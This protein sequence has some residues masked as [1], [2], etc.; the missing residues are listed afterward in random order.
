[1]TTTT[2]IFGANIVETSK[3][4]FV[5]FLTDRKVGITVAVLETELTNLGVPFRKKDTKEAKAGLLFDALEEAGKSV[6]GESPV[7]ETKQEEEVAMTKEQLLE[8]KKAEI[9]AIREA[10]KMD[11]PNAAH[12][13]REM[14]FLKA[15]KGEESTESG[16]LKG[17]LDKVYTA[18]NTYIKN[19]GENAVVAVGMMLYETKK[20]LEKLRDSGS[21]EDKAYARAELRA[22]RYV[23]ANKYGTTFMG[24]I[25]F[26][27]PEDYMQVKIWNKKMKN[28]KT[29]RMGVAQWIPFNSS[30]EGAETYDMDVTESKKPRA[31]GSGL[32]TLPI[33]EGKDG[34]AFVGLPM[35]ADRKRAGVFYDLFRTSDNRFVKTKDAEYL[36]EVLYLGDNNRTFNAQATAFIRVFINQF[37]RENPANRHGFNESCDTCLNCSRLQSK[38]GLTDDITTESMKSRVLLESKDIMQ[39]AQVGPFEPSRICM[40]TG[41]IVDTDLTLT[42]NEATK[43][44]R[45]YFTDEDG[46]FRFQAPND[47][48]IA[49]KAYKVA[50]L[51]QKVLG[52]K[53]V[54]CEWY[55]GNAPKTEHQVGKEKASKRDALGL[56]GETDVFVNPFYRQT[57]RAGR[58]A[59]QTLVEVEGKNKWLTGLPGEVEGP[60]SFRVK[61]AGLTVY[62]SDEIM[63]YA[64]PEALP[65]L[66]AFDARHADVMSKINQIFYV[67]FNLGKVTPAQADAVFEMA[68]AP[69]A[70]MTEQEATKWTNAVYWL[71]QALGWAEEKEAAKHQPLFTQKFFSGIREGAIELHIEDVMGEKLSRKEASEFSTMTELASSNK[72]NR[73]DYIHSVYDDLNA[74]EFSRYLDDAA[75]DYVYTVIETGQD[76]CVVGGKASDTKLAIESLQ[77]MLQTELT[78]GFYSLAK[79]IN[80]DADPAA[81][82]EQLKACAE[83]KAYLKSI[84]KL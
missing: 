2:T 8:S 35:E 77:H 74:S 36:D 13:V 47:V 75:M 73:N 25:C 71:G 12:N 37:V 65:T 83:V 68:D 3:E 69:P 84:A 15:L 5:A 60:K 59:V 38:D 53:A 29:G 41:E 70:D 9:R 14:N 7:A 43:K 63:G 40:I 49:D 30:L 81:C 23:H 31:G 4:E 21:R 61:S 24:E 1:M 56:T 80:R 22:N 20:E 34:L 50:E 18:R 52:Q 17:M 46:N 45:T 82:L 48:V 79:G 33:K 57:A 44:E 42:L 16:S 32:L 54:A 19:I 58:Q 27:I 10:I 28:P 62:G 66:E 11:A 67:A 76:F 6:I 78:T 51:S 26:Q 55:Q 39:L 64:D 72:I